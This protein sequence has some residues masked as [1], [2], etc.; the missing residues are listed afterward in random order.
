MKHK[1][2]EA[3]R[4]FKDLIYIS[5]ALIIIFGFFFICLGHG[6]EK[7]IGTCL[8]IP[9][10]SIYMIQGKITRFQGYF[11]IDIHLLFWS[12][13]SVLIGFLSGH[14]F[15]FPIL[16]LSLFILIAYKRKSNFILMNDCT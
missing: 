3:V 11:I 4:Y 13:L 12:I 6:A 10:V 7:L 14:T 16:M 9:V 5:S 2:L 1:N 15:W 8:T